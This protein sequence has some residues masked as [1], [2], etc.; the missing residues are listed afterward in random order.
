[1]FGIVGHLS[2]WEDWS[3]GISRYDG[4]DE[5]LQTDASYLEIGLLIF[6]LTFVWG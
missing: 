5:D 3:L 6:S 4:F 2:S 1:M